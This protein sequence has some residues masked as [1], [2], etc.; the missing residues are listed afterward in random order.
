M[1]KN[2]AYEKALKLHKENKGKLEVISKVPVKTKEDLAIAYT[3]GVA[4]PCLEIKEKP[5][6]CYEYTTKGNTVCVLS[7][8]S[9]ILGLGNIG[10]LAG[11]PVM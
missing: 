1:D 2:T 8:G 6:L 10:P 7:D 9:A 5:E 3:P 11:L 4:A